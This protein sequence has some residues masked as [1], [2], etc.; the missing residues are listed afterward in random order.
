MTYQHR[1]NTQTAAQ[2]SCKTVGYLVLMLSMSGAWAQTSRAQA[3]DSG[4]PTI[5]QQIADLSHSSYR[6]RQ[7]ARWRLE[8]TPEKSIEAIRDCLGSV[9]YNTGGQL[10]DLLSA[11]ATH[12]DVEVSANARSTLKEYANNVSSVGRKAETA[13]RAI[14]DLKEAQALE[15]L[16]HHI[17]RFGPPRELGFTLNARLN[18]DGNELA[19][20]IDSS[21]SGDEHVVAWIQFLK[22]ID[23]VYFEGP[24]INSQHFEA[25]ACLP[26]IKN[27]KL[28]RVSLKPEDLLTLKGCQSLEMLELSYVNVDDDY[29]DELAELP[30]SQSLRLYGTQI[31]AG[32]AEL[33]AKQLDGIE[34][35][36]GKGG[37]LGIATDPRNTRV[38]EVMGG[39]GAQLAGIKHNDELTHVDGVPIKNMTELRTELGK[40]MAGDRIMI[41][42]T[43][44]LSPVEV[45]ALQVE[46]TLGEDPN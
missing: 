15:I 46:V 13:L 19:L 45:K 25:I 24:A 11:L 33:L 23:T 20:M 22:S 39:S 21:F 29:L 7:L 9:D 14:A 37:Y 38:T 8:Q 30:I 41:S 27:V 40:H 31:T 42:L 28:K 36:C 17:A 26:T 12:S 34:I 16:T 1:L 10:V 44:E 18:L 4:A 43:R 3:P 6:A 5:D 35:Y 32:G 2:W